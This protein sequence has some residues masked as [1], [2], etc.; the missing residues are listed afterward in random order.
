MSPNI[1]LKML[2]DDWKAARA[3]EAARSYEFLWRMFVSILFF[4]GIQLVDHIMVLKRSIGSASLG[5]YLSEFI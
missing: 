1:N 3:V 5:E 4:L 2:I